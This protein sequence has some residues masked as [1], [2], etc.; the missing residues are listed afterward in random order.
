MVFKQTVEVHKLLQGTNTVSC[1]K[2]TNSCKLGYSGSTISIEMCFC[3]NPQTF[4]KIGAMLPRRDVRTGGYPFWEPGRRSCSALTVSR[5]VEKY[6]AMATYVKRDVDTWNHSYTY[7][8]WKRCLSTGNCFLN[9]NGRKVRPCRRIY[10]I[11]SHLQPRP[12][13][14]RAAVVETASCLIII[15]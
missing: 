2:D 5:S 15:Y 13:G 1:V 12:W 7:S 3:S 11:H 10:R 6:S 4:P 14:C 9:W 8:F